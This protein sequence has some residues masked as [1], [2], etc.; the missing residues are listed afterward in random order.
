MGRALC[1]PSDVNVCSNGF[2]RSLIMY[3]LCFL[4]AL[5]R[6][7]IVLL[8]PLASMIIYHACTVLELSELPV[9]LCYSH[10]CMNLAY[11][12]CVVAGWWAWAVVPSLGGI[13]E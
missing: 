6:I 8:L 4:F 2:Y 1:S 12:V 13:V 7:Y 5:F 9:L 3:K 11:R 10:A